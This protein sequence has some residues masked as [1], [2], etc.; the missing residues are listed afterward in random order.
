MTTVLLCLAAA[1]AW[2]QM[3]Q[4][5]RP[6]TVVR[7]V[8]VYEWTG[9]EGKATASR[10]VP[11]SIFIDGELQDAGV[12]LTRPVPFT[13]EKGTVFEL[14]KSGVPQGSLEI[15]YVR[16]LQSTGDLTF[17]DGWLGYGAFKPAP[18]N[19][20]VAGAQKGPLPRLMVNGV[21]ATSSAAGQAAP[22]KVDRSSAATKVSTAGS[23][24]S[25]DDDDDSSEPVLVR[26]PVTP[27]N[28]TAPANGTAAS[29]TAAST[30]AA[31]SG[32]TSAST[33]DPND[34]SDRP[35]LK[36]RSA[37]Q[38]NEATADS[39][40]PGKP[41]K[42]RQGDVASVRSVGSLNDDPDRPILHRGPPPG[43]LNE[44][45]LPPLEG[46][47]KDMQQMVAV[48][49]AKDRP[50][51]DF[52]RTWDSDTERADVLA[53]MEAAARARLAQYDSVT[54]LS[55]AA[56]PAAGSG[57]PSAQ[58]TSPTKTAPA[59]KLA[60]A[61][62]ATPASRS[63]AHKK[64]ASP[65]PPAPAPIP[66]NDESLKGYTLSYGGAA[67]FVYTASTPGAKG[68]TQYV[69]IV[70]QREPGATAESL[71]TA[72]ISVTDSAHLDR[73]PWMRLI[74]AVDAEASNRASLLFELRAQNSRQFALYRVIGADAE[75]ALLTGTNP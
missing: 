7:A 52:T 36:R 71:K 11:V 56:A 54:G 75:Q 55:K 44:D 68:S 37:D 4:V 41:Q 25:V 62:K 10:L 49:D 65:P 27:D 6:E 64:T 58:T 23:T 2:S 32:A 40:R 45:Q 57:S 3:H 74:D 18:K 26:K 15:S 30:P 31:G 43:E 51:H 20:F 72:L 13:L 38:Q 50:M 28:S 47:P 14:D 29:G 63:S 46:F 17:D 8:A 67:T 34:A 21:P 33:T 66:L 9:P 12:Y 61:A 69:T 53:T 48:S 39:T 5:R 35:T 22:Q 19:T 24:V 60:A 73:T 70:A 1:P 59:A 42:R 16:H